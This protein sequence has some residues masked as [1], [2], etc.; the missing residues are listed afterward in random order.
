MAP[1]GDVQICRVA[2]P[3]KRVAQGLED[4]SNTPGFGVQHLLQPLGKNFKCQCTLYAAT[5]PAGMKKNTLRA[6]C[7]AVKSDVDEG[8][9]VCA[10]R[11]I[12]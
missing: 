7:T 8:V 10:Q 2:T 4:I 11:A 6:C 12:I 5:M 1:P 3:R 9:G